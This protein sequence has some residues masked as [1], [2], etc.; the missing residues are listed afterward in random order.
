MTGKTKTGRSR[1]VR[2]P[3]FALALLRQDRAAQAEQLL[4]LGV[5]LDGNG[6]V[7][8]RP[9]GSP[10]NPMSLSAWCR[11]NSPTTD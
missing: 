11:A 8:A 9:D 4:K 6:Y 5:R 1:S 10:I 3:E 7:C 2:I